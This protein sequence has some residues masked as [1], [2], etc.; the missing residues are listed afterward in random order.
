M[1]HPLS[2]V[3]LTEDELTANEAE[4]A[5]HDSHDSEPL[6]SSGG[7]TSPPAGRGRGGGKSGARGVGSAAVAVSS[8]AVAVGSSA[9]AGARGLIRSVSKK[10]KKTSSSANSKSSSLSSSSSSRASGAG[11]AAAPSVAAPAPGDALPPPRI[12]F[13]ALLVF[14][15]L[16]FS[17]FA[18]AEV[19]Y[20]L[21]ANSL[22]MLGDSASMI[23]DAITY[24]MN[25][26]AVL[27][28]QF[29]NASGGGA[30]SNED[31][32][33]VTALA[34]H[35]MMREVRGEGREGIAA[36]SRVLPPF[37]AAAARAAAARAAVAFLRVRS[38]QRC[39]ARGGARVGKGRC[40]L[41]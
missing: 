33:D 22:S 29:H 2:T 9:V 17:A 32:V 36:S 28:A 38:I 35:G 7:G 1:S 31:G 21:A 27:H 37:C 14:S 34:R 20:A 4:A 3:G 11:G 8:S 24:G 25:L 18:V 13:V 10:K 15:F 16:S 6:L 39:V 19:I 23:V 5:S 12:S 40:S 26:A 41:G 30:S